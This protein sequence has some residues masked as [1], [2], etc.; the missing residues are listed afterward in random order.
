MKKGKKRGRER[1]F[2]FIM[3][4]IDWQ[5]TYRFLYTVQQD[6]VIQRRKEIQTVLSVPGMIR[7]NMK[8][9]TIW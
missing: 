1:S 4:S 9:I 7:A 6:S 8:I 5:D 2:V 3:A